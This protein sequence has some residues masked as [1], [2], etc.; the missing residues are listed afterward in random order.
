PAFLPASA[1]AWW[2][3][4]CTSACRELLL[5]VCVCSGF[6]FSCVVLYLFGISL[7]RTLDA[8]LAVCVRVFFPLRCVVFV[9]D[10]IAQDV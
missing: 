8:P 1:A 7:P 3:W 9:R 6:F 10:L 5:R 4:Y 2:R